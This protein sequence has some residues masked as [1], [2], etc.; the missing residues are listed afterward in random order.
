MF[1]CLF[2]F[3]ACALPQGK[4]KLFKKSLYT[5][6]YTNNLSVF[7]HFSFYLSQKKALLVDT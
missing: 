3:F 2:L 6:V 4:P 7:C 1:G 5:P